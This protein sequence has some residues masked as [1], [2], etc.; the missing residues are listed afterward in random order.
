MAE[1]WT[2]GYWKAKPGKAD[3][4]K[5]VWQEFASWTSKNVAGAGQA[6]L[7]QDNTDPSVFYSF[8][9]WENAENITAW[10]STPEFQGFGRSI[11]E[12]CDEFQPHSLTEVGRVGGK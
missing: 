5:R 11:G 6:Y 4:L 8:G 9:P 12:I 10:R 3:E 1:V 7:L 2:L